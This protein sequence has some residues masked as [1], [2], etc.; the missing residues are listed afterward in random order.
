MKKKLLLP[1][2][3][4]VFAGGMIDAVSA[5]AEK[6][7]PAAKTQ[8]A[9][10]NDKRL[11]QAIDEADVKTFEQELENAKV[12][13]TDQNVKALIGQAYLTMLGNKENA[14][15][16]RGEK[17]ARTRRLNKMV[18]LLREKRATVLESA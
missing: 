16:D 8:K 1:V 18:N 11:M 2:L 12:A 3:L 14:K 13:N 15:L 7:A 17:A 5:K 10:V 6:T 9:K 4:S